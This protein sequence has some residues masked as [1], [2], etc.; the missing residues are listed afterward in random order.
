M[1]WNFESVIAPPLSRKG[2]RGTNKFTRSWEKAA[3]AACTKAAGQSAAMDGAPIRHP[4]RQS[5]G[6]GVIL[7][8]TP[9]GGGTFRLVELRQNTHHVVHGQDLRE[10]QMKVG[11]K[12]AVGRRVECDACC[13]AL[14]G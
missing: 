5:F 1:E 4:H 9:H 8:W 6:W 10:L 2:E 13:F 12:P 7:P 14:E 3:R 11:I